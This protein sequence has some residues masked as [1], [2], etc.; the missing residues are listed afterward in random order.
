MKA[1]ADFD[2]RDYALLTSRELASQR[3]ATVIRD[4][5]D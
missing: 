4:G 5:S 2:G 3:A 1:F